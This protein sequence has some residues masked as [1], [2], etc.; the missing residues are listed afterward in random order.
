MI[1]KPKDIRKSKRESL[2]MREVASL[3]MHIINDDARLQGL[4]VNRVAL[5][6][7][8]GMC[9]IMFYVQGGKTVFDQKLEF[10]KLYKPSVRKAIATMLQSRYTPEIVFKFDEQFEKQLN[11]DQ[12]F[13][14]LKDEG[15]L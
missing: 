7:E 2:I 1:P 6:P 12:L 5:S 8:Q 15:Q 11:M 13:D 3:F 14:K 10:L 9:A 4:F